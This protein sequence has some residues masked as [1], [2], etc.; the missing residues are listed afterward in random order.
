MSAESIS[1]KYCPTCGSKINESAT[2]CSV[3]GRYLTPAAKP[4]TQKTVKSPKLPMLTL[5]LPVAI[6]FF[7]ILVAIGAALTF[8]LLRSTGNVVLPTPTITATVTSTITPTATETP[9]STPVPTATP[10]PPV[11]VTVGAGQTCSYFAAVYDVTVPSIIELNKLDPNCTVYQGKTILIPQPT[12]TPTPEATKT[13]SADQAT[14]AACEKITYKVQ[15]GDTVAGIA[16][17]Y[18]ISK[19][20]LKAWNGLTTD[21]LYSGTTIIIP[22]CERLP[23]SGPTP[24][25]TTPPPYPAVNLLL[26]VD[27]A[28]YSGANDS[29][30]LQWASVGSLRQNEFYKVSVE[31]VTAGGGRKIEAYVTDTSY[32]VT[33]NFRPLDTTPHVMRWYIEPVRQTGSDP[34]GNPV[35]ASAGAVSQPRI[36]TWSGVGAV[37]P[38]P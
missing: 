33:A 35:Y 38:T 24:T 22:L 19:D 16:A 6:G 18:A 29:V 12:T 10:L 3:C 37:T 26:P 17:L 11:T 31:D 21:T 30:T 4:E 1:Q 28:P 23:T 2:R 34:Q 20:G 27:G 36:F 5:N 8:L 9:T 25:P 14:Q 15:S 7:V 13:L 32:I